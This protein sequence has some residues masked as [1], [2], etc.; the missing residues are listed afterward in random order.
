MPE[1]V[2]IAA[3]QQRSSGPPRQAA[4]DRDPSGGRAANRGRSCAVAGVSEGAGPG[5]ARGNAGRQ[6]SDETFVALSRVVESND[7][8]NRSQAPG[9]G[10]KVAQMRAC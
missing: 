9:A 2:R 8:P 3:L 6:W 1:L 7:I 4:S 10:W 5:D